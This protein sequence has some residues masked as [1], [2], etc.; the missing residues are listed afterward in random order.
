MSKQDKDKWNKKFQNKPQLLIPREPSKILSNFVTRV[1][2]KKAL[3]LACGSGRHSIFMASMGYNVDAV[4]ISS[5]AIDSLKKQ[6][7]NYNINCIESDLDRYNLK[8][9]YYDF[10]IMTNYINRELISKSLVSLRVDG[11]FFIETY[12]K[13]DFN[14]K[15]DSND[16]NLLKQDELKTFFDRNYEIIFY[17]EVENE[18][19][20]IHKMMKQVILVK[21]II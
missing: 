13:S 6:K 2:S 1:N 16:D 20:E 18:S 3:D 12:M 7:D 14:E 17:D 8:E 5:I 21:K 4:D 10:I 19:Y 9:N 15:K 11:Y